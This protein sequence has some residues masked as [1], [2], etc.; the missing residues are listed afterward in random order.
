MI[1][2]RKFKTKQLFNICL[3]IC[4]VLN[5]KFIINMIFS[6]IYI[7]FYIYDILICIYHQYFQYC[8]LFYGIIYIYCENVHHFDSRH[9]F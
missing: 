7:Y 9:R 4:F 2:S 3:N 1:Y 6:L 8:H 5:I